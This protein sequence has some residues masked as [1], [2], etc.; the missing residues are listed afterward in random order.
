MA[1]VEEDALL[2]I[3][4]EPPLDNLTAALIRNAVHQ[5]FLANRDEDLRLFSLRD[6]TPDDVLYELYERG[7]CLT[8]L[9]HRKRPRRLLE[10]IARERRYPEA[11]IT[12]AVELYTSVEEPP[13]AFQAF[14]T[15]HSECRWLLESLA[16]QLASS[17]VKAKS[18]REVASRHTDGERL[19]RLIQVLDWERQAS[20]EAR[21]GELHRLFDT[22]EPKVWRS[23]ASNP[24]SPPEIL[25]QLAR[26]KD[27][28]LAREIRNGAKRMLIRA[29]RTPGST[30][31]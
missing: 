7:L 13:E 31:G 17:E 29:S 28:P 8:Q 3:A 2:T 11:I 1:I 4:P 10:R 14:L 18:F 23:L 5:E 21:T 24:N 15:E 26:A 19:L 6:D 30:H 25:E 9:A 20:L 12:V 22:R 16:H 27:M